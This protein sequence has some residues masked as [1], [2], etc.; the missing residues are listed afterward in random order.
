VSYGHEQV[1]PLYWSCLFENDEGTCTSSAPTTTQ[2]N[3][4]STPLGVLLK[5]SL[6]GTI[7]L[8]RKRGQV[9]C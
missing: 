9:F 8:Y 5:L 3:F 1:G 4:G 6:S 2:S 7:P